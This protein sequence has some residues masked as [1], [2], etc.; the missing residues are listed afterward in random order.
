MVE[1]FT[2]AERPAR[3]TGKPTTASYGPHALAV[4]MYNESLRL[5]ILSN[6]LWRNP[7]PYSTIGS[8]GAGAS[9][10]TVRHVTEPSSFFHTF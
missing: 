10:R 5:S 8:T 1:L 2:P 3:C 6:E 4:A 9:G 7:V